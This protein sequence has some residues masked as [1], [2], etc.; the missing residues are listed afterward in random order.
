[1]ALADQENLLVSAACIDN[2]WHIQASS[3]SGMDRN[4]FIPCNYCSVIIA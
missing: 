1:V 2:E 4:R 3:K